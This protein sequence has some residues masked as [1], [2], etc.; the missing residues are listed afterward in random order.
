VSGSLLATLVG[1]PPYDPVEGTPLELRVFE[2]KNRVVWRVSRQRG[3]G[4]AP[5]AKRLG[6]GLIYWLRG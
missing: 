1:L 3:A 4:L 5:L 6:P 2:Y